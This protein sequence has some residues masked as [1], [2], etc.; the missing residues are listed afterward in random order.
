M[1]LYGPLVDRWCR[2]A[3][4]PPDAIPDVAQEVFLAAF[5]GVS[6]FDPHIP[7]ATFR[8]WLWTVARSRIVEYFRILEEGSDR[9]LVQDLGKTHNGNPFI[10]AI[11]SS[12]ENLARLDEIRDGQHRIAHPEGLTDAEIEEIAWGSPAVVMATCG[13]HAVEIGATQMAVELAHRM[14]TEDSRWMN[15]VL[16]NVV[17]LLVPSFNPDGQ[18]MVTD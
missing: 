16:D 18:V 5:R 2:S 17:F 4:V 7:N 12:P 9:V 14:A 10:L 15:D 3:N 6:R 1:R 11:L 13:I 8:G